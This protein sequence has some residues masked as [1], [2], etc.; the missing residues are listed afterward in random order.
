[1]KQLQSAPSCLTGYRLHRSINKTRDIYD[2]FYYY[3]LYLNKILQKYYRKNK[4]GSAK[5]IFGLSFILT[6]LFTNT[7]IERK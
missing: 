3:K 1:M 4:P 6:D 5:N 2:I 7:H